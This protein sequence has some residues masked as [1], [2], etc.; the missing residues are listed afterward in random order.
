MH[1]VQTRS[2]TAVYLTWHTPAWRRSHLAGAGKFGSPPGNGY[3]SNALTETR[4]DRLL[5]RT[6]FRLKFLQ[7]QDG[8]EVDLLLNSY[9]RSK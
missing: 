6:R 5:G 1:L 8:Q 9:E 3:C 2:Q 4:P 7:N